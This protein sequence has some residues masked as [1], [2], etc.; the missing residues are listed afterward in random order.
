[1]KVLSCIFNK[2]F[3]WD[4]LVLFITYCF[5]ALPEADRSWRQLWDAG[6]SNT[7]TLPEKRA[8]NFQPE[9]TDL[10]LGHSVPNGMLDWA[11]A[12]TRHS[13][14]TQ[15]LEISP[16]IIWSGHHWKQFCTPPCQMLNTCKQELSQIAWS[17]TYYK[18]AKRI[19]Y[20]QFKIRTKLF[21]G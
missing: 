8:E 20:P 21:K 14:C 9:H 2:P 16:R 4:A 6:A 3:L 1:M 5:I 12:Y 17:L 7:T 10:Q 13:D 19:L 18:H 15:G 11:C